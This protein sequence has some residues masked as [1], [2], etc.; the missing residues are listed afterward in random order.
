M[1]RPWAPGIAW[2]P[3]TRRWI[4]RTRHPPGGGAAA[5]RGRRVRGARRSTW[6]P[7]SPCRSSRGPSVAG[8]I[9][10]SIAIR[11]PKT[12]AYLVFI[13][14]VGIALIF[15]LTPVLTRVHRHRMRTTAGIEIPPQPKWRDLI[16]AQGIAELLRSES[17][18]RQLL[19][20]LLIAPVLAAAAIVAVGVWAVSLVCT[21]GFA[22]AW[23]H[24]SLNSSPTTSRWISARRSPAS[25]GCS[26]PPGSPAGSVRWTPGPRG[27]CSGRAARTSLSTGW[28]S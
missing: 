27:H 23:A 12:P 6:P 13:W 3:W 19:Y 24:N 7:E 16:A 9:V 5:C 18:R 21:V 1:G 28:S 10:W 4:D 17:T 15:L 11:G 22:V 25:P 26:S 2:R 14:L 20:H 8:M